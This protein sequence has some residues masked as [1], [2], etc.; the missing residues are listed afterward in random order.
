M[1]GHLSFSFSLILSLMSLLSFFS[2]I[3][4]QFDHQHIIKLVGICSE[5][6]VMIVMELAKHGELRS[7]LQY[8]R[9]IKL[10]VQ[11]FTTR[12]HML[13]IQPNLCFFQS[14]W[15]ASKGNHQGRKC[16]QN[17]VL[18]VVRYLLANLRIK[19]N[20]FFSFPIEIPWKFTL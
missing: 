20:F 6:P 18:D 10:L 15:H 9:L 1:L 12:W 5:R 11:N 19:L 2:V 8:H 7:Y 3:M 14:P 17:T 4:K 16:K 13:I